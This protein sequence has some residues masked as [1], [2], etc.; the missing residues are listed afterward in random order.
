MWKEIQSRRKSYQGIIPN[1]IQPVSNLKIL[2]ESNMTKSLYKAFSAITILALMLMALP[3]QGAL[4]APG[5]LASTYT[6]NFDTLASSGTTN[7]WTDDTTISGW[8]STRTVYLAGTGSS[9]SGGLYSFGSAAVPTDRALGSIASG[10][11]T[12]IFYGVRLV[13]DTGS[14]ITQLDIS[15]AGEQWRTGGS[16]TATPS[17]AQKI[18][19]QYQIGATSLTTGTWLD[20]DALDFNSPIFG[21]TAASA[22]DGNAAAN[23]TSLSNSIT[24]LTIQPNEEVWLRW[25]DLN[26]AN[27]DHG[28]AVDDLNVSAIVVP[29]QATVINEVLASTAGTDV[30]YIELYGEPSAS[31]AGL[32]LIYV[33]GNNTSGPGAID[34]RYDFA[35]ADTLGLNGFYLIGTTAG[36]QSFYGVTPNADIPT[37][38]LENSSAT[39]ALVET[40]SLTGGSVSGSEV[41][42]DTVGITDATAS[43]FYFGA[44]VVGPD[45]TFFPA[46]V[47]RVTDG[48]DTDASA[49]WVISDFNLGPANT[50]TA[51]TAAD[52]APTVTATNPANGATAVPVGSDITVTFSESVDVAA[53]AI[54]VECPAGTLVA[55]NAAASDVTSVTINPA[56]DLPANTACAILIDASGVT[57][58]DGAPDTLTGTTSFTFT[59]GAGTATTLISAIQTN[60]DTSAAG[61]FT[62]EA[63]VVGD[64]QTQGSGQL[65]GFFLQEEDAEADTDPLTSEGIFVFC[66][67]CPTPVA[68]G[69]K[70]RVTGASSEF[71]GMSQLSGT[72]AGSVTV[73]SSGHTLPTPASVQLPVPGVPSGNLA[74]ATAVINAYF[75]AFEGMLVTFPDTLSVSEYF[76]LARFGQVI[77]NEGGRPRQFTDANTPTAAGFI[78]HQINLAARTVILD[79]TDNRENRPVDTPNTNYY[80]PIPGLSISNFFRGGDTITNLTGVLHWSF[81][82]LT[83]TDAWRIR[84][85]TEVHTYAFTPVNPRPAV[86]SLEGS[87]KVASFNVLNYFLT[88]DT[89]A[90]NDVGTCGPSGTLDC[91][92][93]D[94]ADELLRQR[95]KMLAALSAINADVFGFMEMENSTG[96]EPLADVVAG[97]PGYDF[98]DTGVVGTDAIRV[99]IIYKT[100]TVTP[101]GDFAILDSSVDPRF[102]DTRNRPALA[103]TFK[104]NSTGASF[105]VVVNHL[106][107]KGSGC[108]PGDDDTTTGQG[109]C[110]GTRTQAAEALVDWL[111]SDPT[112]TGEEDVLIIGDLNSNAKEDPIVALQNGGYT[113]M[114]A[115]LGGPNAYGYV[116]DGQLGYLDHALANSSLVPQVADVAEWHINADEIPLFDYND[117]VRSTGE[118]AFE[119]ESDTLPLY[120]PNEFRTS[121]HDPVIVGLDLTIPNSAPDAVNDTATTNEDTPGTVDV[122]AN[123]T[124][125]NGD[126]LT[127]TTVTQGANGTVVLNGDNT[128]TYTPNADFNGT[129][130][131]TYTVSDGQGGTDSAT[132]DVTVNSVNDAPSFTSGGNVTVAEDSGAYSAAWATNISA[133]ALNESGQMLTFM[134]SN[135]TNAALFS[136]APAVASDGTLSFT[137][138][139]NANGTASLTVTLKDNGGTANGGQDTS[140]SVTFTIT[141][142]AV[143][144]DPTANPDSATVRKNGS[145]AIFIL[146]N[147]SDIDG[148]TLTVTS[149][150]QPTHGTVTYSTKNKN[151]RYT[152][153]RGF[154]GTDTFTYTI[155]DGHGGTATATVTITVQ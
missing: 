38:S 114:V 155:S 54:N 143:N 11:T 75:E 63:I 49:D 82:G 33:E 145:V 127:V 117:D 69:D 30:E 85:V 109:N 5:S 112:G 12:T 8:Y 121:D 79:D 13:N 107:S 76:E 99:G 15:Y 106:K 102:V 88:I 91:R 154:S 71:F 20:V 144:D 125:A 84:P 17:V 46:G 133:G 2:E 116:F 1:K 95:T 120:E 59:T 53:G 153:T 57:D 105:T 101:V 98:I 119:E 96:V 4:A 41:V 34:F 137:P 135:N 28:L 24:G 27:N 72:T 9:N 110:N 129:D 136:T 62:V 14:V 7:T 74:A 3:M 16:S 19:F 66:S 97:L 56:S 130:S 64:Y 36:L 10:T 93:A 65:R 89:T 29:P 26:D 6:Q 113:D 68:V 61:T 70:V 39:V 147:D 148:D 140:T 81:A 108:G 52:V 25:Q 45:G 111:A 132:V 58:N 55:N 150:T 31:L 128:V 43:T 86:P 94:S 32:S 118:A 149:F 67:S 142:T 100:S 47:R 42:L 60:D 77:L 50:P 21:T 124:D 48:V 146:S 141:V 83:G 92:G 152:P 35:P 138:A 44:P 151:F 131:F 23:R 37:N 80:H 73:L 134:V 87:L 126:T 139:A 51:G 104:E 78:D 123:D 40:S 122:L 22:L 115:A 18:D 103:Q 90:S